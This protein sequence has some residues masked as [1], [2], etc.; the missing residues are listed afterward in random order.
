MAI[1]NRRG[2][3]V[4]LNPAKAVPG[5]LLV[6]Q[7]GDP[8]ATDGKA[9]YITFA[10][11]D[12]KMLATKSD[13]ETLVADATD[14]IVQD[15]E[16]TVEGYADRAETAATNAETL[17][18]GAEAAIAAKGAEQV[19]AVQAQGAQTIASI[20]EDYTELSGDV[21]DLKSALSEIEPGLSDDA[22]TALLAC[23]AHVAWIDEDGPDYYDALETAL[24]TE[25][26]PFEV[27]M[28]NKSSIGKTTS[29]YCSSMDNITARC[30]FDVPVKNNGYTINSTDT[31]K[32]QV[33]VYNLINDTLTEFTVDG[34]TY[35]GYALSDSETPTWQDSIVVTG[36]YFWCAFKKLDGTDFTNDEIENAFGTIYSV[37]Q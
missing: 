24:Y 31:T 13:V 14:E 5:E 11:G 4:D 8:N 9:V 28:V 30:R 37:E 15:L 29:V 23:L 32:Y 27:A 21:E 25:K 22:K 6:V 18:D 16:D 20:P 2:A 34:T 35:S 7:S 36:N 1:Q 10:S 19:A 33:N 12:I 3:Y 17:V 26:V